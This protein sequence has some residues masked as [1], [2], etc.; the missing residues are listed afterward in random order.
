MASGELIDTTKAA[1]ILDVSP[2]RVRQLVTSGRLK[3]QIV[4]GNFI[5]SRTDLAKVR[6]RKPGRPKK[7]G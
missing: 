6:N 2:R 5:F 3:P 4:G 7:K 1:A